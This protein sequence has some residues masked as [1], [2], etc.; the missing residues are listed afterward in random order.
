MRPAAI[1]ARIAGATNGFTARARAPEVD[2]EGVEGVD[3]GVLVEE[4]RLDPQAATGV[5]RRSK[6]TGVGSRAL[7]T[8]LN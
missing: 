7:L 8:G 1:P 6:T 2:V 5:S 3:V 4:G